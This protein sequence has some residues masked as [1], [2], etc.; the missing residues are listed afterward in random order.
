[1]PAFGTFQDAWN[2][3]VGGDIND[4]QIKLAKLEGSFH[5]HHHEHE[6]ELFLVIKGVLRMKLGDEDGGDVVLNPG[7]YLIVPHGVEHCPVAEPTCEV[8]LFERNSTLNTGNLEN[9]R[10][11]R[12]LRRL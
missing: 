9:E 1:M 8:L 10:T 4:F 5:W 7:E 2:P 3:R 11:V 12:D 6:D